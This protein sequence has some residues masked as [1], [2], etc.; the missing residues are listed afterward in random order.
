MSE[1]NKGM[2][3]ERKMRDRSFHKFLGWACILFGSFW[4]FFSVWDF[5]TRAW[6]FVILLVVGVLSLYL[7]YQERK[8]L[9][10][11]KK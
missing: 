2:L 6:G 5:N 1:F 3:Y 11:I 4:F 10:E 8:E 7:S 9:K